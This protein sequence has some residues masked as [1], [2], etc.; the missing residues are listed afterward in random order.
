MR[1][2]VLPSGIPEPLN[3]ELL[4]WAA[5]FFDGEGSTIARSDRRRPNY[6]QLEL[7][8]PQRG[9]DGIPEVL[10]K[11]QRAMLGMGTISLRNKGE[12]YKWVTRGRV[13]SQ[14]GLALMWP[15]LGPVKRVQ[16][17]IAVDRIAD[18][19]QRLRSRKPRYDPTLI[20]HEDS[21][22]T[23]DSCLARAWAAGFL[24]GEGY[25]GN[26]RQHV[27]KDGS[28][29]LR[30]R[31]SATQHGEVG[32]PADV[33]MRMHKILGGRIER[34]GQPDDFKW[35]VEGSLNVRRV[36]EEVRPWLGHIKVA[37]GE[38]AL[39]AAAA[40]RIRGDSE[41]CVRGHLYDGVRVKAD[42]TVRQTCSACARITERERRMRTGSKPRRVRSP[43]GDPSRVYAYS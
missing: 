37:Q 32:V 9:P 22:G 39:A 33:L 26:P 21:D 2:P 40:I 18:Q 1:E 30:V 5:G 13:A 27:R 11:F 42:G 25:F 7:S 14:I 10:V 43:S 24:D 8:V 17:Q 31:A 23:D 35:V 3:R 16:A 6:Y 41:R 29:A 15:W 20:A 4:A 12:M 34:H 36:L 28:I 38:N 19:Y